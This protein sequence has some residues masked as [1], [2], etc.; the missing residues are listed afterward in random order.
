MLKNFIGSIFK[1]VANLIYHLKLNNGKKYNY[2]EISNEIEKIYSPSCPFKN[3]EYEYLSPVTVDLSIIIPVYNAEK[4]L[5]RCLDSCVNQ[6]TKYRYEIICIDDKSTDKSIEII[7][8]YKSRYENIILLLNDTNSGISITRNRGISNAKGMYLLFV[9]ND[10]ELALDFVDRHL[11]L[12]YRE[13][14]DLVRCSYVINFVN[15][16]K[17]INCVSYKEDTIINNSNNECL[18]LSGYIWG[19]IIKRSIF[20][21]IRFPENYWYEDMIMAIIVYRLCKKS[22][23]ISDILYY[24]FERKDSASR[25]TWKKDDV[26]SLD[27]FYL[28][29]FL[30]DFSKKLG[31]KYTYSVVEAYMFELGRMLYSRTFKINKKTRKNIF[32]LACLF[33]NPI[34]E[35][36]N[37][38][39]QKWD[40]KYLSYS[41]NTYNYFLWK[42]TV[43]A[44]YFLDD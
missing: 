23:Y 33:I 34:I 43:I 35:N 22:V 21:S 24:K 1:F 15:T 32:I 16:N 26:K 31:L 44:Q 8:K 14:A 42:L 13:N 40:L 7:Q 19:S 20:D 36:V 6:K 10:D 18:G 27:Q 12:A 11:D 29:Y 3:N 38:K 37:Y 25:I 30:D 17:K 4:Y 41:F 2:V 28:L 39:T 5:K 9:D